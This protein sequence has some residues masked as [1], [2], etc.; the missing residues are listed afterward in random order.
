MRK[1]IIL[2]SA[3]AVAAAAVPAAAS[4]TDL[5]FPGREASNM[6]RMAAN[7][8]Y[9]ALLA[10]CAGVFGAASQ[11]ESGRGNSAA[12]DEDK[13]IGTRFLTDAVERLKADHKL[14]DGDALALASDQVSVGHDQG[15]ELLAHGDISGSSQWN[16]KRGACMQI[17]DT[18]HH[19]RRRRS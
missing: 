12:S 11:W 8:P 15:V 6:T 19:D 16:W 14:N 5:L 13:A 1:L 3:L 10:E 2:A 17:Q 9:W 18:Y 7:Q 4:D